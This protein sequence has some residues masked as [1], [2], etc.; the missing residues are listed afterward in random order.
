MN[1]G[2]SNGAQSLGGRCR[3]KVIILTQLWIS[4]RFVTLYLTWLWIEHSQ[5]VS[6]SYGNNSYYG[7]CA[8]H[9]LRTLLCCVVIVV[10][11]CLF[12]HYML[13][14]ACSHWILPLTYSNTNN[15]RETV[16]ARVQYTFR[17]VNTVLTVECWLL[18]CSDSACVNLS[19]RCW[20]FVNF[21]KHAIGVGV[22]TT[23]YSN[24]FSKTSTSSYRRRRRRRQGEMLMF[25]IDDL[26]QT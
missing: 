6:M 21:S 8:V 16:G 15:V 24:K 25:P 13:C 7:V 17:V 9:K 5:V 1:A 4:Q 11:I 12:V 19:N 18:G 14:C 23:H 22:L 20:W 3:V 2:N 26:Y 10:C